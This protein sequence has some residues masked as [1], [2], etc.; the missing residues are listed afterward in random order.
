MSLEQGSYPLCFPVNPWR[1]PL[2]DREA[3]ARAAYEKVR[4]K[5]QKQAGIP[6][7]HMR[8]PPYSSEKSRSYPVLLCVVRDS[9]RTQV[10]RTIHHSGIELGWEQPSFVYVCVC[11]GQRSTPVS[12]LM[13]STQVS[14]RA[15]GSCCPHLP[16]AGMRSVCHRDQTSSEEL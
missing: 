3:S 4:H 8:V 12:L 15:P 7:H 2:T 13:S 6:G 14:Q 1:P 9:G 11:G 10:W 5:E 16:S